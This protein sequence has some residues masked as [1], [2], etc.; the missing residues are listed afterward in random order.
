[1]KSSERTDLRRKAKYPRLELLQRRRQA[2]EDL[3]DDDEPLTDWR[4]SSFR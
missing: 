3:R 1:M 2:E 4:H